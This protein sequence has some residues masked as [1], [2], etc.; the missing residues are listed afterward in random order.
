[1]RIRLLVLFSLFT[2]VLAGQQAVLPSLFDSLA[3]L[4]QVEIRL[5]YQFDSLD[6][7]KNVEIPATI[8]IA[9]ASG[10]L[11][12]EAPIAINLRG[13]FR[14]MKCS[15]PP[16]LLNFKKSML[17]QMHLSTIDEMKLVTHCINGPEGEQNVA[18]ERLCYQLFESIT[19]LSYRTVWVS[20]Q[21]CDADHPDSC[22][23]SVGFLIE[24]DKVVSTR[25]GVSEKRLYNISQDSLDY[26]SFK[27]MAAFNFMIGNRDWDIVSARNSKLFFQPTLGKYIV[28]PYD[29]DYSNIVGASYRRETLPENMRHKYDRI[30][31]G[32]YFRDQCSA[33]L[34]NF[35]QYENT[36]LDKIA[37]AP[38]P[39]DDARRAQ[40]SGYVE[41]WFKWVKKMNP[42]ELEYGVVCYYKGGL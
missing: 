12:R 37:H 9:S 41:D 4:S 23:T 3:H 13:K 38:S 36:L 40:I 22:I 27:N 39:L 21:Y 24:P 33:S 19:P 1:M 26:D 11:I 15:M 28:I 18:E 5:T 25:L 7:S 34:L 6:K 10:K 17:K 2:W 30:Y 20:V 42:K 35:M 8:S 16:L 29:F 32:Y 14:R 31:D